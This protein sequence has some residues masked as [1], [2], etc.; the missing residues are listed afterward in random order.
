MSAA[1]S[2]DDFFEQ[3]AIRRPD[4]TVLFS[5]VDF[6]CPRCGDERRGA[7]VDGDDGTAYVEC[8]ACHD[9]FDVSVLSVPTRA[10]LDAWRADA[11]LHASTAMQCADG[12]HRCSCLAL[13]S[14]RRLAPEM[15]AIGK[16]R[17]LDEVV[18]NVGDELGPAQR[19]VLVELGAALGLPAAAINGFVALL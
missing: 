13:A 3:P 19:S 5:L 12:V 10:R 11:V 7:L 15:S 4:A 1:T 18:R 6:V 16:M 9:E 14:C 17:L 2:L 8:S